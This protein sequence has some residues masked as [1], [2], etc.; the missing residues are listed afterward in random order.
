VLAVLV[1]FAFRGRGVG[2]RIVDVAMGVTGGW[3][4]VSS[5]TF[6][7]VTVKWLAFSAG[8]TLVVLAFAG[9][10]VHEVL[11]EI[12][13]RRAAVPQADGRVTDV[14]ERGPVGMAS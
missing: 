14:R 1:A 9:L 3:V 6:D 13:A 5:R 4:V 8:A 7:A 12:A 2:Q 10:V 11:L